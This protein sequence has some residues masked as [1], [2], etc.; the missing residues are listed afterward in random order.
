MSGN[1]TNNLNDVILDVV[2][3]V[4]MKNAV[5]WNVVQCVV[6]W[7]DAAISEKHDGSSFKIRTASHPRQ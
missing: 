2:N 1:K 3:A 5:F 7:L 6:S 4:T